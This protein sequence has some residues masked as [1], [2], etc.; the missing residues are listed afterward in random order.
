MTVVG[1]L[2]SRSGVVLGSAFFALL[3]N[4]T[5]LKLLHIEGFF[6]DVVDAAVEFVPLVIGPLLLLLTLTLYPGGH[7]PADRA[8]SASGSS[9]SGSTGTRAR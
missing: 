2:R 5:L 6:E 1:G 3:G 7:R 4:G 9:A 8:R